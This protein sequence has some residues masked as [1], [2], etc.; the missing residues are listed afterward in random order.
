MILEGVGNNTHPMGKCKSRNGPRKLGVFHSPAGTPRKE[1][2]T[3][4]SSHTHTGTQAAHP[5]RRERGQAQLQ[6]L[7][8]KNDTHQPEVSI[9]CDP[10]FTGNPYDEN[11][12]SFPTSGK[13]V[14]DTDIKEMLKS[15]RGA[16][17]H[18]MQAFMQKSKIEID[19]L[20]ERVEYIEQKMTDFTEAH[21]KLVDD[22]FE[23]EDEL[24]QLKS[25]V[26]DLEDRSSCNN[27]KFRGIPENKKNADLKQFLQK[28]ILDL[29]PTILNQELVIDRPIG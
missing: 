18:G 28:M 21:N 11:L 4:S 14:L 29:I 27:I 25:K 16:I 12:D 9:D 1:D 10:E 13:A 3:G 7:Q 24:K 2:G 17:Q 5:E 20:G 23:L 8:H 22:Q 15:L 19:K 6:Q 26:A